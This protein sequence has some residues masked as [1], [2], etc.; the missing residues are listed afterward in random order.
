MAVPV[1]VEDRLALRELVDRY[2]AAADRR[3]TEMFHSLWWHGAELAVHR[4][5]PDR[6]ATSLLRAP[7]DLDHVIERL[8]R[9]HRTLHLI[10]NHLVEISDD[11]DDVATGEASCTAHHI[12]LADPA[13][14]G[15]PANDHIMT[16][17]YVDRYRRAN[18]HW[19]FEHRAVNLLWSADV[20][21]NATPGALRDSRE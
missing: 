20:A 10:T 9:H 17:R 18:R 13:E 7:E 8:S 14:E 11:D 12:T 19:R 3:D 16:I 6:A 2:A 21:V 15:G 5:G 4:D 1:T